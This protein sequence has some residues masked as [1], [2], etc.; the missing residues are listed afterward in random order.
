M[1]RKVVTEPIRRLTVELPQS[2]YLTLENYCLQRQETK[3]QVIRA[4]IR[5]LKHRQPSSEPN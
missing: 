4:F 1:P 2:E 5:R 3:R